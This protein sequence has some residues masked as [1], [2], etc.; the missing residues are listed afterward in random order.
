MNYCTTSLGR[1]H[2]EV[3]RTVRTPNFAYDLTETVMAIV[4]ILL[5]MAK[6]AGY[7]P[8]DTCLNV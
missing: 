2:N 5:E 8:T 3:L 6:T 4:D 7:V 1:H